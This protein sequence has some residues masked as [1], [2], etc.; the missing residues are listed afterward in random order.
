[1]PEI[2]DVLIV[3][4]FGSVDNRETKHCICIAFSVNKFLLINTKNS[5]YRDEFEIKPSDYEFLS[6]KNRF[7]GC[8]RIFEFKNEQIERKVGTMKYEDMMK[9]LNKIKNSKNFP[10]AE[11]DDIALEL[12]EWLKNY[13]ENQL[14]NL[15]NNR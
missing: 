10:K 13:Q 11:K 8:S 5:G 15:F 9:I 12:E 1:M 2:S 14:K 4:T 3:K 6:G 7:V